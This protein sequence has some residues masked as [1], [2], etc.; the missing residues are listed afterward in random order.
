MKRIL[1]ILTIAAVMSACN[2]NTPKTTDT[3]LN[4]SAVIVT[5]SASFAQYKN[6][7][8]QEL[9][10]KNDSVNKAASLVAAKQPVHSTSKSSS[11]SSGNRTS[12]SGSTS[13]DN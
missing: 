4:D 3:V 2:S 6:W 12:G 8:Q 13:A 7:E 5:D 1:S 10:R 9:A 11:A